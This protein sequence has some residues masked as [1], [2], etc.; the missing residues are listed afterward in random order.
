MGLAKIL[1]NIG[2][3]TNRAEKNEITNSAPRQDFTNLREK[4]IT[5]TEYSLGVRN[6]K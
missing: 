4:S 1:F 2:S 5:E 3:A 6:R